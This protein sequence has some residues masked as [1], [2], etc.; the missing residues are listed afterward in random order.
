MMKAELNIF[1]NALMFYTRLPCPK[2]LVF[3]EQIL[4]KS[5]RYFPL[6]GMIVA[7][8]ASGFLLLSL[9]IFP[10][11][12]SLII[13]LAAVILLTGCIHE[14]G[15]ADFFDG[16][17]GGFKRERILE[18][19]KDS[20]IGS[21]GATAMILL[22]ALKYFSLADLSAGKIP[23]VFIS[24]HG[25]SRVFSV[26]LV[27]S[28]SY[29]RDEGKALHTRY[30]VE[31]KSFLIAATSGLAPLLMFDYRFVL[32]YMLLGVTLFGAFR[33]YLHRKIGGFTGDTLGALQQFT[34]VLFYLTFVA[35]PG[36]WTD[37]SFL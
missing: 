21:Y 34:E 28:S 37:L 5:L 4:N 13:M 31:E 2:N 23:L 30:G 3:S 7:G 12:V 32:I 19:M 8:I 17:G 36:S 11:S 35:V 15:F 16:F 24:A 26:I 18:I 27:K 9:L 1:L 6:A 22:L 25:A 29:A 14:D 20:R 33:Q 10:L